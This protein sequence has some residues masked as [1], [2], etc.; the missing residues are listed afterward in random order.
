MIYSVL[1]G[2]LNSVNAKLGQTLKYGDKIG[3]E[4]NT[5][6]SNGVHLHLMVI[7][8]IMTKS[9][10]LASMK[11]I[12]KPNKQECE[13]FISNDIW[14]N[15]KTKITTNWLGYENHYA[16]DIINGIKNSR[17]LVWNRSYPG[18]VVAVGN[19]PTGYGNYVIV[20]YSKTTKLTDLSD[21]NNEPS[22]STINDLTKQIEALKQ[23][24]EAYKRTNEMLSSEIVAKSEEKRLLSKELDRYKH[25]ESEQTKTI[26]ELNAIVIKQTQEKTALQDKLHLCELQVANMPKQIFTSKKTKLYHIIIKKGDVLYIKED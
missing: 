15:G 4:G 25:I 16:Y 9:W 1:Y 24:L 21:F 3:I 6:K 2:H 12:Y 23:E 20:V 7:E 11:D 22:A 19:S 13:Y 8:G 18:L 26:D 5:G 10:T 17:Q 14:E